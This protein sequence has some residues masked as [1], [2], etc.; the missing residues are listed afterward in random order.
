M[1]SDAFL[2]RNYISITLSGGGGVSYMFTLIAIQL[3]L[4]FSFFFYLIVLAIMMLSCKLSLLFCH[5]F[6][7]E[8]QIEWCLKIWLELNVL[9]ILI[10]SLMELGIVGLRKRG[11]ETLFWLEVSYWERNA[12]VFF[13]PDIAYN[14]CP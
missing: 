1:M 6:L 13:I 10:R 7:H 3:L 5:F 11:V 12:S 9:G 14:I 8:V 4:S 2:T